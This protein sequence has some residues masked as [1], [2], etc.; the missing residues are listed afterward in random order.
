MS[1]RVILEAWGSGDRPLLERLMGDPR[2]TEHLGGPETPDQLRDRQGRYERLEDGD[3]M[4]RIVEVDGGTGVGSVGYW[5]KEWREEQVYEI[6]WMVVPEFQGRG[7]AVAATA[8][9]IES[10]RRDGKY[11]FMHAFPN[12]DNAASNAICR[13]LGFE[14][15]GASEFEYPK[16]HLMTCNDWRLDLRA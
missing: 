2:M 9:A 3:R 16:G 15:L 5:M 12:V 1:A 8:Q 11:R 10:A 13:R 4:F 7:I 6:G 14:L